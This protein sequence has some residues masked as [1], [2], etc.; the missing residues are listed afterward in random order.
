MNYSSEKALEETSAIGFKVEKLVAHLEKF[1]MT[2][3]FTVIEFEEAAPFSILATT[4]LLS[5]YMTIS[6]VKVAASNKWYLLYMISSS[7]PGLQRT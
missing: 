5:N 4:N 7:S 1:D 3:V 2:N 6:P